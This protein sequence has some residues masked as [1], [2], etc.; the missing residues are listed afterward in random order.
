MNKT[1]QITEAGLFAALLTVLIIGTFYIPV[2][3]N[4]LALFLPTPVIILTMKNK[5]LYVIMAAAASIIISGIAITFI[6]SMALGG[7]ALVVGLPMGLAMKKKSS[8]LMTLLVGSVGAAISFFVVFSILEWLTGITMIGMVEDSFKISME[9]QTSINS[10]ADGLGV[11]TAGSLDD[12]QEM[13]DQMIYLMK[14]IM[15]ALVLILS[16]FYSA[17]NQIFSIQLMKRMNI[18]HIALGNFDEFR[19]PKHL[20][21]GGLGMMVLAY[22]LSYLGYVDSKLI[23]ANFTYL[24]MMIFSVQGVSLI[25]YYMKKRSGKALGVIVIVILLLFGFLQ[26]IAY[27]GFF[28][29]MVDL[30]KK[31]KKPKAQ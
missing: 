13:F 1:R 10:A 20:A 14:L 16:F 22:L 12:V 3:G 30:R 31:D 26:Y 24:F 7:I 2:I 4:V 18:D 19:Y 11:N 17:A 29:V 15:P 25:Y 9:L 27:L 23:I 21:Y 28:D 8:N 6:S 5:P